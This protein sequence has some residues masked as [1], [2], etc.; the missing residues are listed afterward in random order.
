[1][2]EKLEQ[3]RDWH[4]GKQGEGAPMTSGEREL[5]RLLN[6]FKRCDGL[7]PVAELGTKGRIEKYRKAE[8][9][10]HA[11]IDE[12]DE[13]DIGDDELA[14]RLRPIIEDLKRDRTRTD[15]RERLRTPRRKKSEE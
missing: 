14:Q 5:D 9:T 6:V 15:T 7:T 2:I 3:A 11:I 4:E 1:M 13:E 12:A 10:L 8:P